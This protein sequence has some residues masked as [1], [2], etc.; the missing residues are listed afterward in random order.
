MSSKP[1]PPG[2][3]EVDIADY[4]HYNVTEIKIPKE[5]EK[6]IEKLLNQLGVPIIPEED[7]IDWIEE[8]G[9]YAKN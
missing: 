6:I 8:K 5:D 1:L 9:K 7:L 2:W 4:E 3:K